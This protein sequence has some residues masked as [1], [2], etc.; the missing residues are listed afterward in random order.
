MPAPIDLS[1]DLGR[2][3]ACRKTGSDVRNIMMLHFRAPVPGTGWG[4]VA[5][6]QPSDGAIAVLCDDCLDARAEIRDICHGYAGENQRVSRSSLTEPFD[7]DMRLH[8]EQYAGVRKKGA[9]CND[10]KVKNA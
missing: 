8:Q 10:A 1:T 3:C 9:R 6:H 2:C 7:H 4:C 5:C